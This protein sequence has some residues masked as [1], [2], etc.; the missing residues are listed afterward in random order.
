MNNTSV[1]YAE[2]SEGPETH[3]NRSFFDSTKLQQPRTHNEGS[4]PQQ[5]EKPCVLSK[6]NQKNSTGD[7]QSGLEHKF[8]STMTNF[9]NIR[10][11]L[12]E[13]RYANEEPDV[14]SE[15]E[16]AQ[17]IRKMCET[18][19]GFGAAGNFQ[20]AFEILEN[21]EKLLREQKFDSDLTHFECSFFVFHNMAAISYE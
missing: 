18:A 10:P 17:S 12:S 19:C 2:L 8:Q 3:A 6:R 5:E 14:F 7:A 4:K 13:K 11:K 16:V 1:I 20:D 15:E 9:R 21:A